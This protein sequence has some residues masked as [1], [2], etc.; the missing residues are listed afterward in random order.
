MIGDGSVALQLRFTVYARLALGARLPGQ[1][2]RKT[3][4]YATV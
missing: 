1:H 4:T 3:A 2:G